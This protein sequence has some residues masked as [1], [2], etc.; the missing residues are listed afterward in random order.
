MTPPRL[1]PAAVADGA[2]APYA[3]MKSKRPFARYRHPEDVAIEQNPERGIFRR[4]TL[5]YHSVALE[6]SDARFAATTIRNSQNVVE[7][8]RPVYGQRS[9]ECMGVVALAAR[10]TPLGHCII[11]QG[12]ERLSIVY[13][14][15]M[16]RFLVLSGASS[17]VLFHNH[18]SGSLAW[19]DDDLAVTRKTIQVCRLLGVPCLDHVLFT[20]TAAVS[21]LE[22]GPEMFDAP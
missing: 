17:C 9:V 16:L 13:Y 7:A 22:T 4:A 8:L 3:M 5:H 19:S 10:N 12:T 18:P 6:A 1:R 21:M 14:P 20:E 15:E 2:T 11:G